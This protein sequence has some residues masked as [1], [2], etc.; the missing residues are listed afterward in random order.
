MRLTAEEHF[1]ITVPPAVGADG[2][3]DQAKRRQAIDA[4]LSALIAKALYPM[5]PINSS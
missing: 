4:G 3:V 2:E 5:T 1:R